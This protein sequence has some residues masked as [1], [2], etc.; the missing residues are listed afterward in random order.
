MN[1]KTKLSEHYSED[2]KRKAVVGSNYNDENIPF[3]YVDFYKNDQFLKSKW[4]T[5]VCWWR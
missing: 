1:L 5:N 2:G 4:F 3:Y